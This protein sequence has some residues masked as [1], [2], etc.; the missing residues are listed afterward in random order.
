[1][2][3]PFDFHELMTVPSGEITTGGRIG[4]QITTWGRGDDEITTGGRDLARFLSGL[5]PGDGLAARLPPRE[6]VG[7]V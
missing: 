3:Y 5:P 6:E 1:M 4:G 2:A 7:R